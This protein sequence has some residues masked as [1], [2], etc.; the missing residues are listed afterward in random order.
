MTH[1]ANILQGD[2]TDLEL[3]QIALETLANIMSYEADNLEGN[4]FNV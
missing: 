4:E 1:L 2:R 3:I